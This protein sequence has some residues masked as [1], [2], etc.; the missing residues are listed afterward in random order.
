MTDP[1]RD[2]LPHPRSRLELGGGLLWVPEE[3][4]QVLTPESWTVPQCGVDV[5]GS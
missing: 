4:A 1:T 3:R 2:T 5:F